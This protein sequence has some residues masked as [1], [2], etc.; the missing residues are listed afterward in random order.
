A[1]VS[2]WSFSLAGRFA[3]LCVGV[4]LYAADTLVLATISPAVVADIGGVSYINWAASLYEAAAIISGAAAPVLCARHGLRRVLSL[5]A[6]VYSLGCLLSASAAT[7]ETL[8]AG[9]T[10]QGLGGGMLMTLCYI[11]MSEWFPLEYWPRLFGI[12]A[13]IWSA[14]SLLGPLVGGLFVDH[15]SWR[16]A[17]WFFGAQ[18]LA[19]ALLG[20]IL[21]PQA[22]NEH[23]TMSWP[24]VPL[25]LLACATLLIAHSGVAS[26][27]IFRVIECV[28]GLAL[29]YCA[30]LYDRRSAQRLLPAELLDHRHPISA[31]LT[32]ILALSLSCTSFW[33]YGP[34]IMSLLFGTSPLH[35]GY[36]LAGESLA[37]SLATI[38]VSRWPV[39]PEGMMI[40]L[41]AMAVA[42]GAAGFTLAVPA[43]AMIAIVTCALL[44]GVGFGLF[45]PA[46]AHRLANL[47]ADRAHRSL[48]AASQTTIQRV[49]YTIGTAAAGIAANMSG[50]GDSASLSGRAATAGVGSASFWVFAAFIPTLCWGVHSAF[51]FA[52]GGRGVPDLEPKVP[53]Q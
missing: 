51:R 21:P 29:L 16:A 46:V 20:A 9:R 14:G 17:F 12:E 7:M 13:L 3:L 23:S 28:A 8:I 32:M 30:A 25:L 18:G 40:R 4:W 36:I 26:G 53:S 22:R 37:W 31:G 47:C 41:G 1:P 39:I 19:L 48:V 33:C 6:V 45:W 49:G 38:V 42:A 2:V 15:G 50:L 34:L 10:I 43:G 44:E 5:A 11:A 24:R 52:A 35:S 27:V